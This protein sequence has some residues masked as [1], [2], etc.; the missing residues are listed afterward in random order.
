MTTIQNTE[1]RYRSRN[2]FRT[3]VYLYRGEVHRL[4]YALF[5]YM[6]K[7][8]GVWALPLIT[9][10]VIDI[11]AAPEQ[12]PLSSLWFYAGLL[13]GIYAQNVPMHYVYVHFF[14]TANRNMEANLR[15]TLARRLQY[16]SM[17]FH[18]RT[19]TGALQTKLV[20]DV[21]L[22]EQLTRQLFETIPVTLMTLV[23][24]I[25]ATSIRAPA[26]LV[27]FV[28]VIPATIFLIQRLRT[29][30]ETR[31]RHFRTEVEQMSSRLVE[32][33]HLIPVTRAHGIEN[34]E[35]REVDKR[36][37][38]VRDKGLELDKINALFGASSWVVFQLA[39]ALCLITSAY[40]AY[41]GRIDIT[42]GDVVLLTGYFTS[43]TASVSQLIALIPQIAKGFESVRSLADVLESPD[44][45]HNE[46]KPAVSDVRGQFTFEEVSFSYPDTTDSSLSQITLDAQSGES[47][48]FVGPS[49]AGKSTL[50]NLIIGFIRPSSG[51]VLLDGV[52]MNALDLR[53]Y[54]RFLAVVPQNT[55]LF[56]GSVR[57]NVLYGVSDVDDAAL[58]DAL[59]KANAADFIRDL[60]DGLDTSIGEDGARLSG[61]QRQRIAIARALIRDP[62]VL[63]LD[64]ATSAL[65]TRSERVIQQA[66]ERLMA[67]RTTFIVAHRLSTVQRA[68]RI[69]V[70]EEGRIVETGKHAELIERGGAYARLHNAHLEVQ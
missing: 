69:I 26:F 43:I 65:D 59:E 21:E 8:S 38:R 9:A 12:H 66:L 19:S 50:L 68:D 10:S 62:R 42:V 4:V 49:G 52:D 58:W 11:I 2:A 56:R 61:G 37:E 51:R 41:T 5:C 48:A 28:M 46:G 30:I 6:I 45:E 1:H 29:P 27:F 60:P 15:S 36:L 17:D 14:S 35:I 44:I 24:A 64:E 63:I 39:N 7:H 57:E 40:F 25:V 70:L 34:D 54:R 13:F 20:R 47:V 31:N 23:I 53:T 32:M 16:L 33:I 55:V 67:N 3:L 22:I 18:Y